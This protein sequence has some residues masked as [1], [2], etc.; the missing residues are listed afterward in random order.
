MTTLSSEAA[1]N[2]DLL[3]ALAIQAAA[4]HVGLAKF[5]HGQRA[6][7]GQDPCKWEDS[8]ADP[9]GCLGLQQTFFAAFPKAGQDD[10]NL[11]FSTHRTA[12]VA[13]AKLHGVA[14][15]GMP[16]VMPDDT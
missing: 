12:V 10:L 1:K 2:L 16:W 11:F 9:G 8:H 14:I 4:E 15:L 3:I 7:A 5:N 6:E 13:C